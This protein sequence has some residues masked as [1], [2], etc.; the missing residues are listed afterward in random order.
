M[1]VSLITKS[2]YDELVSAGVKIYEYTPGFIHSKMI[3][4]DD[5]V[6]VIGTI[7]LDYRSFVHHFECAC[8]MYQPDCYKDMVE[9]FKNTI[10]ESKRITLDD[11][12]K[13]GIFK[14]LVVSFLK[15]F[16]PLF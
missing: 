15:I 14:R 10:K 12:P 2:S 16:S 11:I 3:L 13:Q 7:N 9:D 5:D 1:I 6:A 8:W 4:C